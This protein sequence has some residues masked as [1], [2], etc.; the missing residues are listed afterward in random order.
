MPHCRYARSSRSTYRGRPRSFCSRAAV[1]I[2]RYIADF[3]VP[4]ARLIVEVDGGYHSLR[5]VADARRDRDLT[6]LGYRVLRL[7]A[8][9]ASAQPAQARALIAAVLGAA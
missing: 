6:R 9:L 2:G 4:A 5:R 8:A 3:V 1:P 7:P